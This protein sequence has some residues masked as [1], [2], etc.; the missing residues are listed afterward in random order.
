[1]GSGSVRFAADLR[2]RLEIEPQILQR[3]LSMGLSENKGYL[4]LGSF[5]I[6]I[7]LFRVLY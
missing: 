1:M 3:G 2:L 7:L 5:I 4:I 6:R